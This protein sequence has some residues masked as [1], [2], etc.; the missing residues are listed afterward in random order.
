MW[1]S[2]LNLIWGSPSDRSKMT[3]ATMCNSLVVLCSGSY[4]FNYIQKGEGFEH[5]TRKLQEDV[6][7]H[8]Y[9]VMFTFNATPTSME[10]RAC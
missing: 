5:V 7:P 9:L 4:I 6:R 2:M 1:Y 3:C 8:F 10:A